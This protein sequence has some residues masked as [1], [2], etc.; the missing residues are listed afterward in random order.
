MSEEA[1]VN[2]GAVGWPGEGRAYL[3]VRRMQTKLHD[4]AVMIVAAGLMTWGTRSVILHS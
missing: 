4:W 3:T 2:T 1:L